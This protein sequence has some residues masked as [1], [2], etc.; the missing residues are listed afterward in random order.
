VPERVEIRVG[1]GAVAGR[2]LLRQLLGGEEAAVVIGEG[3]RLGRRAARRSVETPLSSRILASAAIGMRYVQ[4]NP[5][6]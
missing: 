6:N 4:E 2:A 5:R 3:P 1:H